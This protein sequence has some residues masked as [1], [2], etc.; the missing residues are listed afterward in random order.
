MGTIEG[1]VLLYDVRTATKWRIL[2]GHAAA[3]T[4]VAFSPAGDLVV[5]FCAAEASLRWWSAGSTGLFGFLGLSG[6]CLGAS[7]VEVQVPPGGV[8]QL[9]WASPHTVSLTCNNN[10]LGFFTRP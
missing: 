9:E 7:A 4:C 5:S 8:L 3:V 1:V 2:Q 10:A 6:N